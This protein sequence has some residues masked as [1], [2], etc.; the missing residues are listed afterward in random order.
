MLKFKGLLWLLEKLIGR[1]IR[2]DAKAA[3]YVAGKDLTFLIR[4]ADGAGRHY[5]IARGRITSASGLACEPAF[6]MTFSSPS[7]GFRILSAKDSQGAFLQGL[8]DKNLVLSGD[9]VAVMWFQGLTNFL[10]TSK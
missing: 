2:R 9:F 1:A 5:H 8:H 6:T 7:A 4:T 3:A 10:Q